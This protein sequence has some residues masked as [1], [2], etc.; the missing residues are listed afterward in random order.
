MPCAPMC[1]HEAISSLETI[2]QLGTHADI[3]PGLTSFRMGSAA[4][5]ANTPFATHGF[6]PETTTQTYKAQVSEIPK[7]RVK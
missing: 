2:V 6:E 5:F 4:T 1:H 7:R 3:V